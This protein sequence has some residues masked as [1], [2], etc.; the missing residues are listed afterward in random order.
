MKT[1]RKKDGKSH[2]PSIP[3]PI[4]GN[5]SE[6]EVVALRRRHRRTGVPRRKGIGMAAAPAGMLTENFMDQKIRERIR[7]AFENQKI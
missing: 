4:H 3:F 6:L 1:I 2:T 5:D 7:F